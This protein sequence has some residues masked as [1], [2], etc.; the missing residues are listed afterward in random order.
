MC[1]LL[2]RAYRIYSIKINRPFPLRDI[3]WLKLF[4]CKDAV[5]IFTLLFIA[6]SNTSALNINKVQLRDYRCFVMWW[7][8]VKGTR[9]GVINVFYNSPASYIIHQML[10]EHVAPLTNCVKK[11]LPKG[12]Q[13]HSK[14]GTE[15]VLR[16]HPL[17]LHKQTLIVI[18]LN[19]SINICTILWFQRKA[20]LGISYC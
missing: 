1:N 17:N 18:N 3:F 9:R 20:E 2:L 15:D 13:V 7:A 6:F 12:S 5:H 11:S 16:H 10:L 4:T 19:I 8:T 14:P